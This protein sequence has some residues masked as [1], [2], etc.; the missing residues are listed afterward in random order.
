[1]PKLPRL[2]A[3]EAEK[4]I[5]KLGFVLTRQTG[6]HRIYKNPNGKRVTIPFHKSRTLHPKLISM[7]IKDTGLSFDEFVR[8]LKD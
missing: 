7:I 6:S 2:N 1:V 3:R 8:I 4:I 5:L